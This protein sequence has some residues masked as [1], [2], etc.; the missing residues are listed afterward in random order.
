GLGI[1]LMAGLLSL[2]RLPGF[3]NW[4]VIK[5]LQLSP[6]SLPYSLYFNFDKTLIGLFILAFGQT[7]IRSRQDWRRMFQAWIPAFA[8]GAVS[9]LLASYALGYIRFDPKFPEMFWIWL[10]KM[11][12]FTCLAEEAL[13][14]GFIQK[15][16]AVLWTPHRWGR[17]AA[18]VIASVL[19]GL[20]HFAG[21]W[22][23]ILLATLAGLFYGGVYMKT[24]RIESSV[25]FHFSLNTLHLLLFSYPSLSSAP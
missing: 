5:N 7:L 24:D 16:L 2:H 9:I 19:F 20:S 13:F 25:L 3:D 17:A 8:L 6:D 15:E 11:L 10:P 1:L 4:R 23:Y 22:K 18:L 14:R 21:G 12:L